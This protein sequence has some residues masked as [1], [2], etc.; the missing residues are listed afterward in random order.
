MRS[1]RWVWEASTRTCGD[2]GGVGARGGKGM[3]CQGAEG[4]TKN[5]DEI[6]KVD[7]WVGTGKLGLVD[8]RAQRHLATGTVAANVE[9]PSHRA[10]PG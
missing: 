5:K 4:F 7:G 2:G 1:T 3:H 8:A 6:Y 10:N 9:A